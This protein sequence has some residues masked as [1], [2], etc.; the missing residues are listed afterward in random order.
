MSP[1]KILQKKYGVG[2][3]PEGETEKRCAS[4]KTEEQAVALAEDM[5]TLADWLRRDILTLE[6]PD[7]SMRRQE[8]DRL[9]AVGEAVAVVAR[10]TVRASP[11]IEDLNR[12]SVIE[13]FRRG[14]KNPPPATGYLWEETSFLPISQ[15]KGERRLFFEF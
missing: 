14:C 9:F 3:N 4:P 7:H 13:K 6:G 1:I 2:D 12:R 10:R 8:G 5:A 15:R 11:V